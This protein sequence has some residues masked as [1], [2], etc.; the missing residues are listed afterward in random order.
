MLK[1]GGRELEDENDVRGLMPS[2]VPYRIH[3]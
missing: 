3:W 1:G 2:P